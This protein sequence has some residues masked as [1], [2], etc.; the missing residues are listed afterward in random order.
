MNYI[1]GATV[2]TYGQCILL[3]ELSGQPSV[4]VQEGWSW[5]K[6]YGYRF[7]DLQ[8]GCYLIPLRPVDR[9]GE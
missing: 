2:S 1:E 8:L 4:V 9:A 5:R 3:D 7:P 6:A